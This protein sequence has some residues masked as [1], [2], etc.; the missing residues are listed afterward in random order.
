[1]S[2]KISNAEN[3]CLRFS[4]LPTVS[5]IFQCLR[6]SYFNFHNI[7]TRLL[8]QLTLKQRSFVATIAMHYLCKKIKT[9]DLQKK[10]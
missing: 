5:A 1:M 10:C 9:L 7:F 4:G 6:T 3:S 8:S 2:Q